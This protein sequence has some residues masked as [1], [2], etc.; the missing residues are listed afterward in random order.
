MFILAALRLWMPPPPERVK[1]TLTASDGRFTFEASGELRTTVEDD[2]LGTPEMNTLDL[3][4]DDARVGSID[5]DG[6]RVA[7]IWFRDEEFIAHTANR[8]VLELQ[9]GD[10]PP[11]VPFAEEV[12]GDAG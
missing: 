6:F 10:D 5:L 7:S 12:F 1:V 11:K 8:G 9:R 2:E 4:H 3:Y